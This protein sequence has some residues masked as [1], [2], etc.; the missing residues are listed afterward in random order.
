MVIQITYKIVGT[1]RLLCQNSYGFFIIQSRIVQ[2]DESLAETLSQRREVGFSDF[3]FFWLSRNYRT[4]AYSIIIFGA[5]CNVHFIKILCSY[6]DYF[7]FFF[8]FRVCFV[9]V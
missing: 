7:T 6:M 9:W 4:I 1:Y 3:I 2:D 5:V 8:F